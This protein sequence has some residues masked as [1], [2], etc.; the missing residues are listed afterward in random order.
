[1]AKD[2]FRFGEDTLRQLEAIP[3]VRPMMVRTFRRICALV[4][5]TPELKPPGARKTELKGLL[6]RLDAL[7]DQFDSLSIDSIIDLVLISANLGDPESSNYRMEDLNK[8]RH[9]IKFLSKVTQDALKIHSTKHKPPEKRKRRLAW[10]T[11]LTFRMRGLEPT[12]YDDGPYMKVLELLF[13]EVF[14]SGGETQH[15][16]HGKWACK[17]IQHI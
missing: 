5:A 13:A 14:P 17:E 10:H 11:A 12:T 6:S 3:D 9:E 15:L 1:M 2:D 4:A 8:I 7:S 16:R